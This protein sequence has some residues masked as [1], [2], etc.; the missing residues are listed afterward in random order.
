MNIKLKDLQNSV[1]GAKCGL[2]LNH[3]TSQFLAQMDDKLSETAK[4]YWPFPVEQ[5][6][7]G[8]NGIIDLCTGALSGESD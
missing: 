6:V 7:E 8:A 3:D 4:T 5:Q 2:D 1:W